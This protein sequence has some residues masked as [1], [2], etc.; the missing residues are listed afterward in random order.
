MIAPFVLDGAMSGEVFRAR[1]EQMS[2]SKLKAL[3]HKLAERT[4][5]DLCQTIRRFAVSLDPLPAR[6]YFRHAGYARN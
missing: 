4:L 3:R 1:I 2:L 5:T 6:N